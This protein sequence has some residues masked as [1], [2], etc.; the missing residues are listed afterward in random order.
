MR[1]FALEHSTTVYRVYFVLYGFASVTL[2]RHLRVWSP[3]ESR[4]E[5]AT[6]VFAVDFLPAPF[7]L[8]R[9]NAGTTRISIASASLATVA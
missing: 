9:R 8:G 1:L 6:L 7:L 2:A 4:P 3:P 5:G